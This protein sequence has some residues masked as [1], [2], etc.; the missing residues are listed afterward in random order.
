MIQ[1]LLVYNNNSG[2]A[3]T[4]RLVIYG[5]RRAVDY[6]ANLPSEYNGFARGPVDHRVAR[7]SDLYHYIVQYKMKVDAVLLLLLVIDGGVFQACIALLR[8]L[9][10]LL[11]ARILHRKDSYK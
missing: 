10:A 6:T 3:H 5:G 2:L 7:S 9:S 1:I 8:L 11:I 4:T